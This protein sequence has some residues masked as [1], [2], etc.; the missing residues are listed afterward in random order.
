MSRSATSRSA[1]NS[2][3]GLGG[4]SAS[5][6]G[7]DLARRQ[8]IAASVTWHGAKTQAGSGRRHGCRHLTKATVL[9]CR[10]WTAVLEALEAMAKVT[11][12]GL[13]RGT[14][15]SQGSLK[16]IGEPNRR[17]S[18]SLKAT[19]HH[20][21]RGSVTWRIA[22]GRRERKGHGCRHLTKATV[23]DCMGGDGEGNCAWLQA[24]AR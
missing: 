24:G 10:S 19:A 17:T 14:E 16:S 12:L 4:R 3:T 5:W 13:N 18:R 22:S 7:T 1:G 8:R 21:G 9:D 6:S 23:L 20:A 11:V 15:C 2:P